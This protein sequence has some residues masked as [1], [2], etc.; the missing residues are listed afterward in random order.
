MCLSVDEGDGC[1]II[2]RG[3]DGAFEGMSA[4]AWPF[5]IFWFGS[6]IVSRVAF[7]RLVFGRSISGGL[8]D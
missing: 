8:V 2:T 4:A 6:S 1:L 7:I 5:A 3:A